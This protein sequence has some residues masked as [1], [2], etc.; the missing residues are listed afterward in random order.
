MEERFTEMSSAELIRKVYKANG[1]IGG[2]GAIRLNTDKD[3]KKE[4][5]SKNSLSQLGSIRAGLTSSIEMFKQLGI[6]FA[7]FTFILT[8]IFST[9]P[10]YMPQFFKTADWTHQL[11]L[12]SVE[13]ATTDM[14]EKEKQK[15]I[16]DKHNEEVTSYNK[17]LSD[18]QTEHLDML[19]IVILPMLGVITLAFFRFKWLLSVQACVNEAYQEK[20]KFLQEEK[21]KLKMIKELRESRLRR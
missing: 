18:V 8:T 6:I 17:E 19:M 20:E 12:Q 5:I 11:H 10:M 16:I 2:F 21:D 13:S 9:L 14:T 1:L 4:L 7:V 3:L 15:Y